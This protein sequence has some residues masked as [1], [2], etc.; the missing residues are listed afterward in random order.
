MAGVKRKES[1]PCGIVQRE[2]KVGPVL[3]DQ[4]GCAALAGLGQFDVHR[5]GRDLGPSSRCRGDE[6]T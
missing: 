1:M 5:C 2:P 3:A 4:Y 6:F